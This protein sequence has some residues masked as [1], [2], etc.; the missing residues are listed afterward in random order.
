MRRALK[1]PARHEPSGDCRSG[2]PPQ[3]M[4]EEMKQSQ[5]LGRPC[6]SKSSSY[7]FNVTGR[8][9]TEFGGQGYNPSLTIRMH[10]CRNIAGFGW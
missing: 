6:A 4:A 8:T 2:G 3:I 1:S 5:K 9:G 7:R 10:G